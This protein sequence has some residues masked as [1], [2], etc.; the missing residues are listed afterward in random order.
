[1]LMLDL[2]NNN[3]AAR[4]IP[5][6]G[7][8]AARLGRPRGICRGRSNTAMRRVPRRAI[9]R[10]Q[11]CETVGSLVAARALGILGG[12]G[13]CAR[14]GAAPPAARAA[15]ARE[16]RRRRPHAGVLVWLDRRA[17]LRVVRCQAVEPRRAGHALSR[18]ARGVGRRRG[19]DAAAAARKE[20]AAGHWLLR[21]GCGRTGL[22][23][24]ATA[25]FFLGGVMVNTL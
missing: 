16:V 5:G 24:D 2:K 1:M 15:D 20:R 19:R 14:G 23:P 18:A 12:A 4:R 6:G 8:L 3:T 7:A 13:V 22:E 25:R 11:R 17:R 21:G 10:A 9:L